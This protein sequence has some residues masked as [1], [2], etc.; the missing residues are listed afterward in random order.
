MKVRVVNALTLQQPSL[1]IWSWPFVASRTYG[2][3]EAVTIQRSSVN[4]KSFLQLY[5]R[6]S[7]P[8]A[9]AEGAATCDGRVGTNR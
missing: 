9:N 4:K 3:D 2:N 1:T 5:F 6:R 8:K 7:R